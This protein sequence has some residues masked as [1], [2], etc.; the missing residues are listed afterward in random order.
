MLFHSAPLVHVI[1]NS[2][3]INETVNAILASGARAVCADSPD[4]AE[5]ITSLSDALVINIGMP[6]A[7][8]LEAMVRSGRRANQMGIPV[9]LDPV[10]AAASS[11]RERIIQR[12]LEEI[13]FAAIRGNQSEI[14][15]LC[16]VSFR[17]GG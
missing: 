14:A 2:V 12:L 1:T 6:S 4:E 16:R 15:A 11:F 3:T 17:S 13:R 5:Q 8:K 10:G 7:E 9:V